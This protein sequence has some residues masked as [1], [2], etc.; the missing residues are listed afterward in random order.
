MNE[1]IKTTKLFV[2]Y[3]GLVWL[4]DEGTIRRTDLESG[5]FAFGVSRDYFLSKEAVERD[6]VRED[7]QKVKTIIT[8]V[9]RPAVEKAEQ[10]GR[11]IWRTGNVAPMTIDRINELLTTNQLPTFPNSKEFEEFSYPQL[12]KLAQ[13]NLPEVQVIWEGFQ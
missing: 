3:T 2:S 12:A 6:W 10:D 13:A 11:V 7:S 1:N 9:V 5:L 4:L 8:E